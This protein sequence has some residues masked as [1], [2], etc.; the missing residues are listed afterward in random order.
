MKWIPGGAFRMGDDH[1]CPEE[2]PAHTITVSGFWMDECAYCRRDRPAARHPQMIDTSTCHMGFRC[3]DRL[4]YIASGLIQ[5]ATPQ[6]K[7]TEDGPRR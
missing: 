2:A 4:S 1:A 5:F 3:A 7:G 6:L